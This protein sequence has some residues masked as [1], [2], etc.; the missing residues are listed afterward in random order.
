[1]IPMVK[2]FIAVSMEKVVEII[3]IVSSESIIYN[4][5]VCTHSETFK[6]FSALYTNLY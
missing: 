5:E 3:R 6:E 4:Y 2:G 1:M